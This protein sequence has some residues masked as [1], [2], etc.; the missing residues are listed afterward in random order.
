MNA[1]IE[2]ARVAFHLVWRRRWLALGVAWGVA[3]A[4]WLV[5]SLIPNSYQ[6]VARV[7]VQPQSILPQAVG[8]TSNDQ[9][10]AITAVRQTLLSGDNLT[11][12]VRSTGLARQATRQRDLNAMVARLQKAIEIKST[13][14]NLYAISVTLS[15]GGFSDAQNARLSQAVAQKLVDRFVA[16]NSASDAADAQRSLKFMDQQLAERGAQLQAADSKRSTFDSQYL[17]ALPG[18]GSIQDRI[19]MARSQIADIDAQL[20]GANSSLAAIQG[21]LAGTPPTVPGVTGAGQPTGVRGQI[22]QLQGQLAADRAQG[23]TDQHPD[24]VSLKN[25]IARLQEIASG[26]PAATPDGSQPNPAYGSLR[27]MAAEKQATSAALSARKAQIQGDLNAFAN[28]QATQPELASQQ[29]ELSRNYDVLK[30]QYDKLLSDR[31]QVKLRADAQA[32][33]GTVQIRVIDPPSLPRVP[34]KPMRP[35]LLTGV[36][37]IGLAAGAG[38]AFLRAKLTTSFSTTAALAAASG[39]PVLGSIALVSGA[40][41][42]A[43]AARQLKWFAGTGGALVGCWV[44]L[45]AVEFVERGLM[46]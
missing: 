43:T 41:Q 9:A 5:V 45:L 24:V 44:L 33:A 4:G 1:I 10:A 34:V 14:D 8:I 39:L 12:V 23:W 21:Q 20:A 22:A 3:L 31:E 15:G 19:G 2:E 42:K 11:E 13:Q 28:I 46:A 30:Q 29:A 32:Q 27:A 7:Y 17:G 25:Q 38:V 16:G 35:L 40:R 26:L 6:S 36:L 18:A 37:L